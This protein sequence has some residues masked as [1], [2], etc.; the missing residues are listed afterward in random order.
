MMNEFELSI[1]FKSDWHVGEGAGQQ[2]YIDQLIR[3]TPQ[4]LPYLPAKTL[5]GMLRDAAEQVADGLGGNWPDW[6]TLLF[7]DQPR[8]R[9]YSSPETSPQNAR[10]TMEPAHLP[11]P[12]RDHLLSKPRLREALTFIKP[13]I[14][15]DRDTGT[16]KDDQLRF[17]EIVR[18]GTVLNTRVI[19]NENNLTEPEK[20]ASRALLWA[21]TKTVERLGGKRRRGLGRCILN[22]TG[23]PKEDLNILKRQ[24]VK[25]PTTPLDTITP[26]LH[27]NH[28]S[29]DA[30]SVIPLTL[31]LGT[32]VVVYDGETGNVIR[33]LDYIPGTYL[34]A[35]LS[36]VLQKEDMSSEWF[37][38]VAR[39]DLQFS[40]AYRQIAKRRALP[41]P[42]VYFYEKDN[43]EKTVNC[44]CYDCDQDLGTQYKQWRSGYISYSDDNTLH[45]AFD[46][47]KQITT[48]S[49]IDDE[50]Q[51][52]T[53]DVGG[54]FT[55]EAIPAGTQLRANIK[56]RTELA[57]RWQ[58]NTWSGLLQNRKV[59]L[60]KSKK[61]DYG[62]ANVQAGE[63][64]ETTKF[65]TSK[66]Q[67][68]VL[69]VWL[70]S[71]VLLRNS[72][73]QASVNVD[74]LTI[75]LT[76]QLGVDLQL[77]LA[78]FFVRPHRT[79]GWINR[80][81]KP[82][83]SY[84]ALQA[85]SCVQFDYE[86][87]LQEH[88]LQRVMQ[89]GI[90]ERRAEGY[91]EIRI[92]PLEL[93]L[94]KP[95]LVNETK[96]QVKTHLPSIDQAVYEF[97]IVVEKAAWRKTITQAI[98]K[99]IDTP[100]KRKEEFGWST[101]GQKPSN[102]QLSGLRVQLSRIKSLQDGRQLS[103]QWV[104]HIQQNNNEKWPPKALNHLKEWLTNP[105]YLWE[106]LG[107]GISAESFATFDGQSQDERRKALKDTL[108]A[109]ALF[110]LFISAIRHEIKARQEI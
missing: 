103:D 17:Q 71:D 105:A 21:A 76:K 61:D 83:P 6:V 95:K 97:A 24:D 90:G 106:K 11:E 52:P 94:E 79:E 25:L 107:N 102:S 104:N 53:S 1:T 64:F 15:I 65:G 57:N 42:M 96:T 62:L 28:D 50:V 8:D 19:L 49:T 23:I 86:G 98:V 70:C 81:H 67:N 75:E 20:Q 74:D 2:G 41:I 38:A 80:W 93:G 14:A 37:A 84:V 108:W 48:H 101:S 29:T 3:R 5:G 92:N 56:L 40:H 88:T 63:I 32:P 13:G 85:G 66:T 51:R 60:G 31:T 109:E 82:R 89:S 58:A 36:K 7:G 35:A 47:D 73:L 18:T 30:W 55:F 68:K 99:L 54:V 100:E 27:L 87:E 10:I 45:G 77:K 43:K 34:L 46:L 4:G 72:R 16:A 91:G 9:R 26:E 33:S 69:N 39:G 44:L 110:E 78:Q 59:R 22:L 12:L